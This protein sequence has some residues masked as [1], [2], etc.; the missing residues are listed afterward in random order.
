VEEA[1]LSLVTDAYSR[2]IVD[3]HVDD[4]MKTQSVKQ[5]FINTLKNRNSQKPKAPYPSFR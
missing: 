2:K 4:N 5:A 1:Y 3:C